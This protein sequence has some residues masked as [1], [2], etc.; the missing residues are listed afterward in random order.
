[1]KRDIFLLFGLLLAGL[2]FAQDNYHQGPTFHSPEAASLGKYGDIPVSHHTG[3][4]NIS[5]PIYTVTDGPLSLPISLSYHSSGIRVEEMAS[6]VG[7]GWSLNAGGMITRSV[8]GAP[9][10]GRS[11][12]QAR[13]NRNGWGWYKDG[14]IPPEITDPV[15]NCGSV[16]I[17]C[18]FDNGDPNSP[19]Y[20]DCRN[21]SYDAGRGMADTEPDIFSIN[22]PGFSGKF[23]FNESGEAITIPKSDIKIEP[24]LEEFTNYLGPRNGR[25][26]RW[27]V[28]T[29][30]GTKYF[31]GEADATENVYSGLD[32]H[33]EDYST[34]TWYLYKMESVSGDHEINLTY[35]DI[36]Y[37]YGSRLGQS[38]Q[39]GY[40]ATDGGALKFFDLA[41]LTANP[42]YLQWTTVL[43]KE[44]AGITTSTGA[45]TVDFE[46]S[47]THRQD[48]VPRFGS[49]AKTYP[50][51]KIEISSATGALCK[52]FELQTSHFISPDIS[53]LD[54][55]DPNHSDLYRLKLDRVTEKSC[56]GSIVKPPYE[57]TYDT[58]QTMVRRYSLGRDHWG[59]YNGHDQQTSLLPNGMVSTID[60]NVFN[61]GGNRTPHTS[62]M[63]AWILTDITYPTGGRVHFDY[64]PHLD[65]DDGTT[66]IGGLRIRSVERYDAGAQ[67]P[68]YQSTFNYLQGTYFPGLFTSVGKDYVYR[69]NPDQG[70]SENI[71]APCTGDEMY[72]SARI[73]PM[74]TSQGSHITYSL[75]EVTDENEGVT[76]YQYNN[77]VPHNTIS[78]FYHPFV[79]SAQVVGSGELRATTQYDSSNTAVANS[80]VIFDLDD[81]QEYITAAKVQVYTYR[82]GLPVAS[83]HS[84]KHSYT[85]D[86]SRL[87]RITEVVTQDGVT[88]TT[89]RIFGPDHDFPLEVRGIR[90]NGT[91]RTALTYPHNYIGPIYDT[92]RNNHQLGTV[93]SS[94][95][96]VTPTG[97][98]ASE[99]KRVRHYFDL[100]NGV[101]LVDQT[102]VE[103]AGG[104]SVYYHFDYDLYDRVVETRQADDLPTVFLYDGY[105]QPVAKIVNQT[106]PQ[107]SAMLGMDHLALITS[108]N[109]TM[110]RTIL[111]D[112][113][114]T[115]PATARMETYLYEPGL[116]VI[117]QI[118][119]TG[120]STTFEYDELGRL[121]RIR[122][123]DSNILKENRYHYA[124]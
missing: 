11:R 16:N 107:V 91:Y 68:T 62:K 80:S 3:T 67:T 20:C 101:P 39:R 7:L 82:C 120:I 103:P 36:S 69:V 116:G 51:D 104:R 33:D 74:S 43:G 110:T 61:G 13:S 70:R 102:I 27:T 76:R 35:D 26:K 23:L 21:Y 118:G 117:E 28:T 66:V 59:Y 123:Q 4:A 71:F 95:A 64:E 93:I 72:A 97:A 31:F 105:H 98:T 100:I 55:D 29:P 42:N 38:A 92:L 32:T 41:S 121:L 53:G 9:D 25:F 60:G 54:F 49:T 115:L 6:Q 88:D 87:R 50:L 119:V 90:S 75:V 40:D 22:M 47:T 30:D 46:R 45:V 85:I 124:N 2:A 34:S 48:L 19:E 15:N 78:N 86:V 18:F 10:E 65:P 56:S 89:H 99:T 112:L 84:L 79:P 17:N 83:D 14:G 24:L 63:K 122:D 81:D 58:S 57:F 8:N 5:I 52:V 12:G 96:Y 106:Y 37:R 44:I 109:N 77:F 111:T 114:N 108:K 1:M 94:T 73:A 113:R